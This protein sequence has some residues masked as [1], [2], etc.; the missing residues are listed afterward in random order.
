MHFNR[1][2]QQS[3]HNLKSD[4]CPR[5]AEG[6]LCLIWGPREVWTAEDTDSA[7]CWGKYVNVFKRFLRP[8]NSFTDA[9]FKMGECFVG[10]GE[11]LVLLLYQVLND[12]LR[13]TYN[14]NNNINNIST[15]TLKYREICLS[16]MSLVSIVWSS[17][18]RA[19]REW[20]VL[21]DEKKVPHCR[22]QNVTEEAWHWVCWFSTFTRY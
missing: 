18:A 1:K 13:V 19:Q 22:F 21:L 7:I 2:L 10:C 12:T 9:S 4:L 20:D 15:S 5:V 6:R 17:L 11:L 16:V 3:S 14:N 8:T